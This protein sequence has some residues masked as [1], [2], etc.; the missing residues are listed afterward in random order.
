MADA[1]GHD[2][3]Q[4]AVAA[5][6]IAAAPAVI[7][8]ATDGAELGSVLGPIGAAAG[9]LIA[10][11]AAALIYNEAN[12]PAAPA[13]VGPTGAMPDSQSPTSATA[14]AAGVSGATGAA[15]AAPIG[16]TGA[17]IRANPLQGPPGSTSQTNKPDGSPKQVRRYGADG[18]PET[19]VDHDTH[20]SQNN[21]HAHDWGR[22]T[23]GSAPTTADR[24]HT[25]R[26]VT[27]ND[28]QS[29]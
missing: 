6:V 26:P 24:G 11:G 22:P 18:Y 12:Q 5:P 15:P 3:Q 21:P 28:P 7:A 29:R 23:D 8:A 14:P 19:D 25:D 9:G 20:G 10:G 13:P 4:V 27:P 2:P 16:A 17:P 1:D